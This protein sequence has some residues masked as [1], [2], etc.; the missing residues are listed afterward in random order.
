MV[1]FH[2]VKGHWQ[3]DARVKMK[4]AAAQHPYTFIAVKAKTKKSGGG[5]DIERF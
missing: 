1:E 5:W 3:D 2:E 4:V